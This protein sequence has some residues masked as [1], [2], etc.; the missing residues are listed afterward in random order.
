MHIRMWAAVVMVL[1]VASALVVLTFAPVAAQANCSSR[2]DMEAFLSDRY[3]EA[4]VSRGL[5]SGGR[6][7]HEMWVN[8][9]TGT[10]TA[11]LTM[12]DGRA[13]IAMSGTDWVD[14]E[15]G[16]PSDEGA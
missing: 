14:I 8:P 2:E 10:W 3:G 5:A 7:L 13:C 6:T 12:T 1:F 15:I 4:P 16:D 9:E 11:V